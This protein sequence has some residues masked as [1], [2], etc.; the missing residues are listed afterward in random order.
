MLFNSLWFLPTEPDAA[1]QA[2]QGKKGDERDEQPPQGGLRKAIEHDAERP[3]HAKQLQNQHF[4]REI[5]KKKHE[6][7]RDEQ[8][9]A[10][11]PPAFSHTPLPH[12]STMAVKASTAWRSSRSLAGLAP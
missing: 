6:G 3:S 12:A 9:N 5:S 7:E 11:Q 2:P 8:Y 10:D 4:A 1:D